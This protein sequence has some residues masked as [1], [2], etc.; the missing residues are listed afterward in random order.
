MLDSHLQPVP[1]GVPGE[2]HLAGVGLARGYY[3]RPELTADKFIPNPFNT[4]KKSSRL[5]K[6]G[7]LVRYLNHGNL[8]YLGRLDYQVKIRGFRIE[9]TEIETVLQQHPDVKAC[10]VVVQNNH[11]NEQQIIAYLIL[12]KTSDDIQKIKQNIKRFLEDKLTHYMI[13]ADFIILDQFP[14]TPSGKLDQQSLPKPEK[15]IQ[16]ASVYVAPQNPVEEK[17]VTIWQDV[18]KVEKV[19]IHDH[20]FE[21]GGHSLL[22]T[23]VNSRL[24]EAFQMDIPLRTLFEK[25]TVIS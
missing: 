22:A 21:L 25:P 20:F 8:E 14:L 5:Y 17:I 9:L 19:G 4:N 13:P 10:R 23:R 12:G 11:L 1:V 24:R 6:T 3:N 16:K 7:D 18:L 2:L 15:L